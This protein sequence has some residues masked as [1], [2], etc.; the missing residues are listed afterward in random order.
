MSTIINPFRFSSGAPASSA[1][2]PSE[3]DYLVVG[4][5]GGAGSPY[6]GGGGG[7]GGYNYTTAESVSE[8]GEY[9]ITVGTGGAGGTNSYVTTTGAD[10]GDDGLESKIVDPMEMDIAQCDGGGGGGGYKHT[11]Q[12]DRDGRDGGSGGGA[13]PASPGT[14][15][16]DPHYGGEASGNGTGNDG[17]DGGVYG[18]YS[19]TWLYI[20][21]A[22][23]GGA[24][25]AGADGWM[26][27]ASGN[28]GVG[29]DAT[30]N[31]I[32]GSAVAYAGGGGGGLYFSQNA[33]SDPDGGSA[34]GVQSGGDGGRY[35]N[36]P[37]TTRA[38]DGVTNT[39]GGGGGNPNLSGWDGQAGGSGIVVIKY[40][41]VQDGVTLSA[42]TVSGSPTDLSTSSY[43]IYKWTGS[44]SITWSS[45]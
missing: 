2:M 11:E 19:S 3:I 17:G 37:S 24:G 25:S 43:Y 14:G 30:S 38:E 7:A 12:S 29:G 23:G 39:G 18:A 31:S 5:G 8:E 1:T 4:G 15:V 33:S 42:P 10:Q 45:T 44:G 9:I 41:K 21:A 26:S 35:S 20:C 27:G 34:G 28:I 36:A 32:T 22:G 13:A 16:I 40:A 6:Y